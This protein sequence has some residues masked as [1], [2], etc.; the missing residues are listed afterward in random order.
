[1]ADAEVAANR[2]GPALKGITSNSE[3]ASDTSEKSE[4]G[5]SLIELVVE[6]ASERREVVVVV[7]II[8]LSDVDGI[9]IFNCFLLLSRVAVKSRP[10][11]LE[12]SLALFVGSSR[13]VG[14]AGLLV[15][16]VA[17]EP[18]VDS[19][20]GGKDMVLDAQA[21]PENSWNG[22]RNHTY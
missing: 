9:S 7:A 16:S 20:S 10:Y 15:G 6:H 8:E 19:A 4:D 1:M 22:M 13:K 17:V 14:E 5:D 2:D 12:N 11:S 21:A 18:E 3:L